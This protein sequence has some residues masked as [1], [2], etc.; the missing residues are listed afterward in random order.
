MMQPDKSEP[1]SVPSSIVRTPKQMGASFKKLAENA[2]YLMKS[3]KR[4]IF[5]KVKK[6]VHFQIQPIR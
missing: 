6:V 2:N 1:Y 3:D 5:H 4:S